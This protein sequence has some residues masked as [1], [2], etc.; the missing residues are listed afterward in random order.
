MASNP[1]KRFNAAPKQYTKKEFDDALAASGLAGTFGDADLKLAAQNPTAG[2]KL[3]EAKQMYN[4]APAGADGDFTRGLAR[5]Q[6]E[7]IRKTYGGYTTST[8]GKTVVKSGTPTG[9]GVLAIPRTRSGATVQGAGDG[10]AA[11]RAEIEKARA[12]TIEDVAG[13]MSALT[14]GYGSSSAATK[15][16]AAGMDYGVLLAEKQQELEQQK[17]DRALNEAQIAASLGDYSKLRALGIDTT[18]FEERQKADR[19]AADYAT[20]LAQAYNAASIGDYSQLEALGIDTSKLKADENAAKTSAELSAAYKRA[21]VGDFSAL[22]ALGVDTSALKAQ[23][24]AQ[25]APKTTTGNTGSNAGTKP[26]L[27]LKEAEAAYKS[28]NKSKN[29]LAALQYYYGDDYADYMD[30]GGP[31]YEDTT[32][33]SDIV[34]AGDG[35]PLE[36]WKAFL[37]SEGVSMRGVMNPRD[38]A[39]AVQKD[40]YVSI[41]VGGKTVQYK[42]Y[43]QYLDDYVATEKGA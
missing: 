33:W 23:W 24:A 27:S 42:N 18:A 38:F 41:E 8:D 31:G 20:K 6:A 35:L 34:D 14:G 7:D 10:F 12:K 15:A 2:M 26:T 3:I 43:E 29:V 11:Y 9:A 22:D 25:T 40:G 28:G 21:E 5:A 30:D 37:V 17:Y 16:A 32:H 13:Q 19:D 36:K 39:S 1:T 4:G